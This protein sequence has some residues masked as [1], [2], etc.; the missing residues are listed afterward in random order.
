[1]DV[2]E[3]LRRINSINF[4]DNSLQNLFR[5]Q[6]N[7]LLNIPFENLDVHLGRH[8]ECNLEKIYDKIIVKKRGGF[9]CELNYLFLWL[10]KSLGYTATLLACRAYRV[11]SKS[12]TPWLGHA[13]IMVSMNESNFIVD[14]GFSQNF[15]SPLKFVLNTIQYDVT[16]HYNIIV[17]KEK[18]NSYLIIKCVKRNI[19]NENDWMPLYKFNTKPRDIGDFSQMVEFLQ[20][21]ENFGFYDRSLCVIHTTY[22]ILNLVGHRL[23][24]IKFSDSIEKSKTHS[25]LTKSEVFDAIRNIYGI[26]LE[27]GENNFEPKGE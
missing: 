20:S 8:I 22:T 14:V 17:D 15:R 7:H 13:A 2:D 10:L 23:S 26:N 27:E 12:W 6:Q 9:C 11:K 1:M 24:E 21:K 19:D 3:Y 25:I 5:L 18:E 16:G 4:K